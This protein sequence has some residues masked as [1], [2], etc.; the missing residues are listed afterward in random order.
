NRHT[1]KGVRQMT[2][3]LRAPT[4]AD[5]PELG[6]ICF[7]AFAGIADAHGFPRD[8]PSVEFAQ[9]IIGLLVQTEDMYRT[10]AFDGGAAKGSNFLMLFDE[11]AGVGPISV[12]PT[13]Q[14]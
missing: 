11:A 3:D 9:Q 4:A 2:I 13:A 7:E 14:G 10:A 8:F 1:A 12:D 5:V 6:R